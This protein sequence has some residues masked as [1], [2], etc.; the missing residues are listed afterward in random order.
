ML[1][2]TDKNKS[3]KIKNTKWCEKWIKLAHVLLGL[4]KWP[5]EGQDPRTTSLCLALQ[6]CW[7]WGFWQQMEPQCRCH[8]FN[9]LKSPH[10]RNN[11]NQMQIV[12]SVQPMGISHCRQTIVLKVCVKS[13]LFLVGPALLPI[14]V[15][16][17][18]AGP[19][20]LQLASDKSLLFL[21]LSCT[22]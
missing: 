16:R 7:V 19:S 20:F 9:W 13:R 15:S 4:S 5:L 8:Y 2:H 10:C 18:G 11:V 1:L 21:L 14:S 22:V 6:H 3:K 17:R 12:C